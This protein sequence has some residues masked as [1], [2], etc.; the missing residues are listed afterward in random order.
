ML[1]QMLSNLMAS[2]GKNPD[3]AVNSFRLGDS[4][5][6]A[7]TDWYEVKR[8]EDKLVLRSG[9]GHQQSTI[10][11]LD[12]GRSVSSLDDFKL[13]CQVRLDA[14]REVLEDGFLAPDPPEPFQVGKA[15]GMHYYGGEKGRFFCG[16]LSLLA[17]NLITIYVEGRDVSPEVVGESFRTFVEGLR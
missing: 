16:Y 7:P 11:T 17:S 8:T 10:T 14:E 12:V 15:F 5:I 2:S 6:I 3:G 13:I 4:T 9:D 1:R